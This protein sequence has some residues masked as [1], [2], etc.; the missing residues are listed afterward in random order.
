MRD[1]DCDEELA[2]SGLQRFL[3]AAHDLKTPQGR[4]PFAF[5]LHQFI[6]GPGKVHGTLEAM[7]ER[8]I[9]L[10]AQRFAPGRQSESVLLYP[11]H[12]CRDCGQ[13]YHPLWRSEQGAVR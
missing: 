7:H 6:S 12:F 5:K 8:H 4:A 2:R 11:T 1:A 10:D 13:E 9:T 3:V